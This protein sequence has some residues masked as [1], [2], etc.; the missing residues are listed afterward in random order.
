MPLAIAERSGVSHRFCR[1]SRT[2]S[3]I[4]SGEKQRVVGAEERL[5]VSTFIPKNL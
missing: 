1:S 4:S 2:S 5:P 3:G